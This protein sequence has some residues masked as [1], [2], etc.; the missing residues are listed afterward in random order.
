MRWRVS[1]PQVPEGRSVELLA[2]WLSKGS[3]STTMESVVPHRRVV[4]HHT[5]AYKVD[6]TLVETQVEAVT[7]RVSSRNA[8]RFTKGS[9]LA[10]VFNLVKYLRTGPST[11]PCESPWL[12]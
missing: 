2:S 1:A 11:S 12:K 3:E 4:R 5:Q 8:A 6:A 7:A 10:G 9:G